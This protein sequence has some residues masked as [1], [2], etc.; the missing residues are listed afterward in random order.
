VGVSL[1]HFY[2][3]FVAAAL[4]S[5]VKQEF[6]ADCVDVVGFVVGFVFFGLPGAYFVRTHADP[7]VL[8]GERKDVDFVFLK[9][10]GF[11]LA[12]L[13]LLLQVEAL[14]L[15]LLVG[16]VALKELV[17]E[18]EDGALGRGGNVVLGAVLG[19]GASL[20]D[21]GDRRQVVHLVL[22]VFDGRRAR[23]RLVHADNV[24]LLLLVSWFN[25]VVGHH[26]IVSVQGVVFAGAK[27]GSVDWKHRICITIT[28]LQEFACDSVSERLRGHNE[29]FFLSGFNGCVAFVLAGV[30]KLIKFVV[31]YLHKSEFV[32]HCA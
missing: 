19:E 13:Q 3:N 28:N 27:D 14:G 24:C 1:V 20:V 23:L 12:G 31:T 10:P 21:D 26:Y 25:C 32:I 29:F 30:Q 8:F 5:V 9:G 4:Q 15:E 2:L 17:V 18:V 22:R 6:A 7:L 16:V 11:G